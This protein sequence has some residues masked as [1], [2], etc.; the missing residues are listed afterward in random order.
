MYGASAGNDRIYVGDPSAFNEGDRVLLASGLS[1]EEVGTVNAITLPAPDNGSITVN[2]NL[3][4]N[5]AAGEKADL[6]TATG[7]GYDSLAVSGTG[8]TADPE[9]LNFDE[10]FTIEFNALFD[11]IPSGASGECMVD[12][13]NLKLFNREGRFDVEVHREAGEESYDPVVLSYYDEEFT[14]DDNE[15]TLNGY[16]EWG[17]EGKFN[18][19]AVVRRNRQLNFF[20]NGINSAET[21]CSEKITG[22][23]DIPYRNVR[24]IGSTISGT[25]FFTGWVDEFKVWCEA[26]YGPEPF[27]C[28]KPYCHG[29]IASGVCVFKNDTRFDD[30]RNRELLIENENDCWSEQMPIKCH[31]SPILFVKVCPPIDPRY[32]EK[33]PLPYEIR[34]FKDGKYIATSKDGKVGTDTEYANKKY[35][36]GQYGL[37]ELKIR[38]FGEADEGWYTAKVLFGPDPLRPI[39]IVE[40]PSVRSVNLTHYCEPC[41][42]KGTQV[43]LK[44][45]RVKR[46]EDIEVGEKVLGIEHNNKFKA[47]QNKVKELHE[48]TA[49]RYYEIQYNTIVSKI[50]QLTKTLKVTE[51]HPFFV[52]K[53][54]EHVSEGKYV[55]VK[56]ISEGDLLHIHLWTRDCT[57][58][59]YRDKILLSEVKRKRLIEKEIPVYNL[60]VE[61]TENYFAEGALVHNKTRCEPV[62]TIENCGAHCYSSSPVVEARLTPSWCASEPIIWKWNRRILDSLSA[63][64]LQGNGYT[65]EEGS[66]VDYHYSR[67]TILDLKKDILDINVEAIDADGNAYFSADCDVIVYDCPA[68]AT[69][70]ATVTPTITYTPTITATRPLTLTVTVTPTESST[71]TITAT[72]TSTETFTPT[73]TKTVTLTPTITQTQTITKTPTVTATFTDTLTATPTGTLTVTPTAT[74]TETVTATTTP[75][76]TQTETL[77]VTPTATIT[78][79]VTPTVTPSS[80]VTSTVTVSLTPTATATITLA[81]P[82]YCICDRWNQINNPSQATF[83]MQSTEYPTVQ[84]GL[85][86]VHAI[87]MGAH[88][89]QQECQQACEC[90]PTETA[91]VSASVSASPTVTATISDTPTVTATATYGDCC[92][93]P[94]TSPDGYLEEGR[95]YTQWERKRIWVGYPLPNNDC[96]SECKGVDPPDIVEIIDNSG[97]LVQNVDGGT[98][99][100]VVEKHCEPTGSDCLDAS[101]CRPWVE[102]TPAYQGNLYSGYKICYLPTPTASI[103]SS[104]SKTATV[105][106]TISLTST[107]TISPT[108]THSV[109]PCSEILFSAHNNNNPQNSVII[110]ESEAHRYPDGSCIHFTV[111]GVRYYHQVHSIGA[112]FNA[113]VPTIG[114]VSVVPLNL[115]SNTTAYMPRFTEMCFCEFTHTHTVSATTTPTI[116]ATPTPTI[117]LTKTGTH[118][119]TRSGTSTHTITATHTVPSCSK[120]VSCPDCSGNWWG[121]YTWSDPNSQH[122]G[123]R[124]VKNWIYVYADQVSKY[125]TGDC[126]YFIVGGTRYY[127]EITSFG[128]VENWFHQGELVRVYF[129]ENLTVLSAWS[130]MCFCEFTHTATGSVTASATDTPSGTATHT[131]TFTR[132]STA[133]VSLT[134]TVTSSLTATATKTGTVSAT[135]TQTLSTHTYTGTASATPTTYT[136]Y[137]KL[138]PCV[139]IDPNRIPVNVQLNGDCS[140]S[141]TD[142]V[143][144]GSYIELPIGQYTILA[145]YGGMGGMLNCMKIISEVNGGDANP[146]G[147]GTIEQTALDTFTEFNPPTFHPDCYCGGTGTLTVTATETVTASA[148]KTAPLTFTPSATSPYGPTGTSTA[149]KGL[150]VDSPKLLAPWITRVTPSSNSNLT[151]TRW[152]RR[153]Y[154]GWW[155]EYDQWTAHY[156]VRSSQPSI[157]QVF[158]VTALDRNPFI[159]NTG[160]LEYHWYTPSLGEVWHSGGPSRTFTLTH[161]TNTY[162]YCRISYKNYGNG[163]DAKRCSETKYTYVIFY[164]NYPACQAPTVSYGCPDWQAQRRGNYCTSSIVTTNGCHNDYQLVYQF[165]GN[166]NTPPG[167]AMM[168]RYRRG[169]T[170]NIT[171][172]GSYKSARYEYSTNYW[173]KPDKL[174]ITKDI[175]TPQHGD[176]ITVDFKSECGTSRLSTTIHVRNNRAVT[177]SSGWGGTTA[178]FWRYR[179]CYW[180][181]WT[182]QVESYYYYSPTY[183]SG[184]FSIYPFWG[185]SCSYYRILKDGQPLTGYTPY[186][187]Y[188]YYQGA[189]FT[190]YY[191]TIRIMADRN[192]FPNKNHN[193]TIEIYSNLPG[194]NNFAGAKK[195]SVTYSVV[196]ADVPQIMSPWSVFNTHMPGQ[197]DC[198]G[199]YGYPYYPWYWWG[200]WYWNWYYYQWY[201]YQYRWYR[202]YYY[203]VYNARINLR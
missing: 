5:H 180:N 185:T 105:T 39:S 115:V 125:K 142:Y 17:M 128:A 104:L 179:Q 85:L 123:W 166:R 37:G 47:V 139:S 13:G 30:Q 135:P 124:G 126:V 9:S 53:D 164:I 171:I 189:G 118:T 76:S 131:A 34:W 153:Q 191:N 133:T 7:I 64:S 100:T 28:L 109:P 83:C 82:W 150:C 32:H 175:Y 173:Y 113:T 54:N 6:V 89:S 92:N 48:H 3:Y 183:W 111:N 202:P 45:N 88:Q 127:Y 73:A 90:P 78:E 159:K 19:Y 193:I 62:L 81:G 20:V 12:W 36:V 117:S 1:N 35:I 93:I 196:F 112:P 157:T 87:V 145:A 71:P 40:G 46:I 168:S 187:G 97:N 146:N 110:R 80:T 121:K 151:M 147:G 22:K 57:E 194:P 65:I 203:P 99:F 190:I 163:K 42:A 160:G 116:T 18:H 55:P 101:L 11:G 201:W 174:I 49:S 156:T 108:P 198:Y 177:I 61:N 120:V 130:Y 158:S 74:I 67:L 69:V 56:D 70:S 86:G 91:T 21:Y 31:E 192:A 96:S 188:I 195:T 155:S 63:F 143:Y 27:H 50:V 15:R 29:P 14:Y 172:S 129:N 4:Y 200:N 144:V 75:S 72:P 181:W 2:E 119:A 79:T 132:T 167:A 33:I 148:T 43:L 106:P 137:W 161:S 51:D 41:F 95:P 66:T 141:P 162:I 149:T 24:T 68:T 102:V 154:T 199:W 122:L 152:L 59:P 25:N 165:Y 107:P 60:S 182:G 134:P 114:T 103:T 44:E 84:N 23:A 186:S 170:D 184:Y 94:Y 52:C 26:I 77:T 138:C 16:L 38:D 197:N 169:Y 10:D 136:R 140:S 98:R 178:A 58:C 176:V 8:L